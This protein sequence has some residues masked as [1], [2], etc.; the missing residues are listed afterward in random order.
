[1]TRDAHAHATR[2]YRRLL[3]PGFNRLSD[4]T[5]LDV[6]PDGTKVAFTGTILRNL[7][8]KENHWIHVL[9]LA[10]GEVVRPWG[11]SGRE[12]M[13]RWSPSGKSIAFLSDRGS[14]GRPQPYVWR[15]LRDQ[16]IELLRL[17]RGLT[18]EYLEWCKD[19]V[20]LLVLAAEPG[21]DKGVMSGSGG[22]P[23]QRRAPSVA[24]W[25]PEVRHGGTRIHGWRRLFLVNANRGDVTCCSPEGTNVWEAR[26]AGDG[27]LAIASSSPGEGNWIRSRL[28]LWSFNGTTRTVY[29]PKG[30]IAWPAAN[31]DGTR[32]AVVE[33]LSSDRGLV[34]GNV[35]VFDSVNSSPQQID[36][37]DVDATWLTF[38][39]QDTL[40]VCGVRGMETVLLD[41]D[42]A[43]DSRRVH[44]EG[45]V[46]TPNDYP[47]AAP[48]PA[49]GF[50][51]VREGWG[52]PP[53]FARADDGALTLLHSLSH[54]GSE[55]LTEHVGPTASASWTA[56][57][58]LPISG[59]VIEPLAGSRPHPTV[60]LIHGGPAY[61][62][63]PGWPGR[64][65]YLRIAAYLLSLGFAVFLPN[66]RGSSGRGQQF[67]SLELGDYGGDE[68]SDILT[69]VDRLV[70]TGIADADRLAVMGGSHGGYM[71]CVLTTK[72]TRFRV[73]VAISP[74]TDWYS[75]H[76]GSNIPEID[77]MYLRTDLR[78]PGG[79]HFERSP[80]FFA[81]K[82]RTPTL[83]TAGAQDKCTPPSQAVEFHQALAAN[84]VETQLALYPL[85]GHGVRFLPA[86]IDLAARS[87]DFITR[88][89]S[90]GK[91]G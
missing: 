31:R 24:G 20:T 67:L 61:L 37:L 25:A 59:M 62:W 77:V 64:S 66:P 40:C 30:Q 39:E 5:E 3:S 12:G 28:E 16:E 86:E 85:E 21:A 22:T 15:G 74:V 63:Q 48:A 56:P 54:A 55:W 8:G 60:V 70:E 45:L 73:A 6:S 88:H 11:G 33:G 90:V 78:E 53:A 4:A 91:V 71:T 65:G 72:T 69:G 27:L 35:L 87:A 1:M 76:F 50:I 2:F 57:D 19:G 17:P 10:S 82:S 7:T 36:T 68:V 9:D 52:L 89:T 84:H 42:F 13:A 23:G 29:E 58:G 81:H 83:L 80:V 18:P 75:Q 79:K 49:G 34:A 51:F 38:R 43:S 26:V 14:P 47:I 32:F 46:T 41:V 44:F